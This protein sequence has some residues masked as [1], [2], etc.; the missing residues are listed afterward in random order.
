MTYQVHYPDWD[1][2]KKKKARLNT[3]IN[4]YQE[5]MGIKQ[6]PVDQQYWTFSGS[7]VGHNGM[8]IKG[9]FHQLEDYGLLLKNQFYAVD[10]DNKVVENNKKIYPELNFIHGDFLSVM[11]EY[12]IKNNFSP[13]IINCDNVRMVDFGVK[14]L[15]SL[16]MFLE[17][18]SKNNV[19]VI[20]NIMLNHPYRKSEIVKPQDVVDELLK[21]YY[22]G[23]SWDILP[24]V[25]V[26][27]GTGKKSQTKM[28]SL[29][30][31]KK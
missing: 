23:D 9:E 8:P 2:P 13:A 22:I 7:Y 24:A 15:I 5:T 17:E 29:V 1:C 19:L 31:L 14:Y 12:A 28:G 16:L 10:I 20:A 27:D 4:I 18:N 6:I 25:Y 26:Y 21:N 11:K 30:L 3:I